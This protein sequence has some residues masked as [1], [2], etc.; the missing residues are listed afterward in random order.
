MLPIES[1]RMPVQPLE[2]NLAALE[3]L[4]HLR[5]IGQSA[6]AS[7]LERQFAREFSADHQL[8][9]YGSLAPGRSNHAQLS[10][11]VGL[12]RDGYC[13]TGELIDLGWGT[14]LGYPAIRWSAEG[15]HVAVHLF[16]SSD[17]P[18]HW[19]RLDAFEGRDYLRILAPVV[20]NHAA[21]AV[22]NLYA[23]R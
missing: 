20:R 15:T 6:M 17:L 21:V 9:V 19:A 4:N 2:I 11:L 7:A 12:W 10:G 18:R 13:V 22:A 5:A 1:D 23:V 8:A 16:V 3:E 14:G